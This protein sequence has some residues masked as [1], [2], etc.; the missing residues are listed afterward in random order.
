MTDPEIPIPMLL[1]YWHLSPFF[2]ILYSILYIIFFLLFVIY[3]FVLININYIQQNWQTEKCKSG[4]ILIGGKTNFNECVK[5][6]LKGVVDRSTQPF[7]EGGNA[8]QNFYQVL[9]NQATTMLQMGNT[10]KSKLQDMINLCM[11]IISKLF[12][13]I[14]VFYN[15]INSVLLRIKAILVTQIYFIISTVLT[16][17]QS[18]EVIL[19][20]I[21]NILIMMVSLIV[22]MLILPFSWGVALLFIAIF[23]S[24]SIPLIAFLG[25]IGK[26]AN[27]KVL[28]VPKAPRMKKP[29]ICFD[30]NTIIP[31]H[32]GTFKYI[33]ELEIGD[34][35]G[36]GATVTSVL[37]LD[38]THAKMYYLNNIL[39]TG[40]HLVK[41]KNTWIPVDSHPSSKYFS[42]Y[43]PNQIYC[44]NTS[45]GFIE[46]GNMVFTDWD[47]MLPNDFNPYPMDTILT[48][49][50]GNQVKIQSIRL[51]DIIKYDHLPDLYKV[52]GIAK[53]E[54]NGIKYYHLYTD[55]IY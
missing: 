22:A 51:K 15:T 6:V 36:S 23:V 2:S 5:V 18:L 21:I 20:I 14:I 24:I 1:Y 55:N 54:Y 38:S 28:K 49:H 8:L 44:I 52:T 33:N 7:R 11:Q 30:K 48:L 34:I 25:V 9:S 53:L 19:N 3:V 16:L 46:I 10:T 47:E 27:L 40:S 32:N 39:V 37:I 41:Y 43:L 31:I 17:K 45:S 35:L 12:V 29:H 42:N 13:P 50:N 4:G 26:A